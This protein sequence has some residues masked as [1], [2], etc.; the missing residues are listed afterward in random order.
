MG[1]LDEAAAQLQKV[2]EIHPDNEVA[3]NNLGSVLLRMGRVDEAIGHF[4]S[5]LKL[6][7]NSAETHNNIA[8]VLFSR[9][10][11]DEPEE[12][13]GGAKHRTFE[14]ASQLARTVPKLDFNR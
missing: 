12:V 4:H 10:Q 8:G 5:A 13:F 6:Q 9:G 3:Q 7:P 1:R 14:G 2:V 11:M